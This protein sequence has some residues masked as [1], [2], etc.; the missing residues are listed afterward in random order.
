MIEEILVEKELSMS[1]LEVC[2][3]GSVLVEKVNKPLDVIMKAW[4]SR[5]KQDTRLPTKLSEYSN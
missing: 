4:E 1:I 3:E 5:V 2:W